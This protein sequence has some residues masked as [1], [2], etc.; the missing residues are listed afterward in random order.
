[1]RKDLTLVVMI[2]DASGSMGGRAN[3][4]KGSIS[5]TIRINREVEGEAL[6]SVY[7]FDHN[8][9]NVLDFKN[10]KDVEG[11]EY[12]C[13]GMTALH[14]AVAYAIDDVG[15]KLARMCEEDRPSNVQVMIL[16]DG[17]ENSSK[18]FTANDVKARID[19]QTT[20]YSWLITYVG[21]NQ[22]AVLAGARMGISK[23]L[24]ATYT[25]N[26]LKNTLGMVS[27]KMSSVRSKGMDMDYSDKI[28][29]T[30]F[31]DVEREA[32]VKN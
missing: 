13:G 12:Y 23:G 17:E 6:M 25:D 21:S 30:S 20:K 10:V 18:R 29:M 5:E 7:T 15:C 1:M 8:V 24:C 4:V 16:T 14:D 28:N 11:V 9:R 27:R 32:L 19:E 26:N 22:D 3:D 31:N 2:L